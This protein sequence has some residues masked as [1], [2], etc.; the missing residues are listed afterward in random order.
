MARRI[1]WVDLYVG[2][3][4]APDTVVHIEGPESSGRS[5][6]THHV[7][8]DGQLTFGNGRSRFRA[9]VCFLGYAGVFARVSNRAN[10]DRSYR[11]DLPNCFWPVGHTC[12]GLHGATL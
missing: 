2:C 3:A 9:A 7:R 6:K 10:L 12:D 1:E 8:S 5:G 11:N 4:P